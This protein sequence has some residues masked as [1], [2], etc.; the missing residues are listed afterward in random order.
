MKYYK[1]RRLENG[2]RVEVFYEHEEP[3]SLLRNIYNDDH[4][5]FDWGYEGEKP[6]ILAHS[7]LV[8]A[9]GLLSVDL[10]YEDLMFE[11]IAH[12]PHEEW[13][14]SAEELLDFAKNHYIEQTRVEKKTNNPIN[15]KEIISG[16]VQ[17]VKEMQALAFEADRAQTEESSLL[18]KKEDEKASSPWYH[19]HPKA[20]IRRDQVV[21]WLKECELDSEIN[22][23]EV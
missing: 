16:T 12:L 2:T 4:S 15:E 7:L 17:F 9:V 8:D 3:P 13:T 5:S 22:D 21:S 23:Q 6:A 19:I 1:G 18:C 14:M 11:K 20:D 10:I